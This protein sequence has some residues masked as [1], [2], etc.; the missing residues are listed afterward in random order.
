MR[1]RAAAV[2]EQTAGVVARLAA[3]P[4]ELSPTQANVLWLRVPGVDGAELAARG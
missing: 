1:R 3:T 4:V 2:A